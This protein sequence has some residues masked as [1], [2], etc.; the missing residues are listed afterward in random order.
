MQDLAQEWKSNAEEAGAVLEDWA[1]DVLDYLYDDDDDDDDEEDM[2]D[3]V[4]IVSPF[5]RTE[6]AE[7]ALSASSIDMEKTLELT[8][9]NV[10]LVLNDVR[11]YLISDGGN[12][13]VER[14][15]E[16]QKIVYLKLEGACGSCASS[17]VTMQMGVER[18]LREKFPDLKEILQVEADPLSKPTELTWKAVEDEVNR[19]KPAIIAMGGVCEIVKVEPLGYVEL[20]FRGANK[21]QQGLELAILDVPFVKSV[22]FVMGD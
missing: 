17:T 19:L 4:G 20:K 5:A 1:D 13:K 12:V 15:D 11:P 6:A 18:V 2:E 10:D 7:E 16:L 14:V 3:P 21:V 22:N 9:A 8:S